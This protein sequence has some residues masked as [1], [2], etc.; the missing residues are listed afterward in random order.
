M[1]SGNPECKPS[2]FAKVAWLPGRRGRS[3]LVNPA[4]VASPRSGPDSQ[5]AFRVANRLDTNVV[6]EPYPHLQDYC[7]LR[8]PPD[9]HFPPE[10]ARVGRV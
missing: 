6:I 4:A 3:T 10:Y 2:P 5:M 7:V 8:T 9:A 1:V